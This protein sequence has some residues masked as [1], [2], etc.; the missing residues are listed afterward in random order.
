MP[1]FEE[2]AAE[3]GFSAIPRGWIRRESC[4]QGRGYRGTGDDGS[5]DYAERSSDLLISAPHAVNHFCD[6]A[7]KVADRRTGGLSKLLGD[8]LGVASLAPVG[9]VD[10][11]RTW[12]ER[13]DPF[14]RALDRSVRRGALVVDLHGMKDSHGVDVCLG[15]GPRPSGRVRLLAEALTAALAPLHVA[16]DVPF[17]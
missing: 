3:P 5:I 16:R 6:G 17:D 11:W 10:D 12:P 1:A 15:F 8:R 13:A 7:P 9:A 4:F 2:T 14:R